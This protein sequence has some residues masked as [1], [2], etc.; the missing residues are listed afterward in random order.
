MRD[1]ETT[2]TVISLLTFASFTISFTIYYFD[3]LRTR[4]AYINETSNLK[5]Y[6]DPRSNTQIRAKNWNPTEIEVH[7]CSN[8]HS[9]FTK[10][11]ARWF[12]KSRKNG[13]RSILTSARRIH[14]LE[15]AR[16]THRTF[17]FPERLLRRNDFEK[18]RVP[19]SGSEREI[20]RL[21][22]KNCKQRADPALSRLHRRKKRKRRRKRGGQ[23]NKE[24]DSI[25]TQACTIDV[26]K[27]NELKHGKEDKESRQE[28]WKRK[29]SLGSV[30]PISLIKKSSIVDTDAERKTSERRIQFTRIV[31]T[32]V[33]NPNLRT[34]SDVPAATGLAR[35][36]RRG[37]GT[38]GDDRKREQG[39]TKPSGKRGRDEQTSR[40]RC[41]IGGTRE[42]N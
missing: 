24:T 34:P 27:I 20:A 41:G 31:A 39:K 13:R 23:G 33:W 3:Y 25:E 36:G 16:V 10:G 11:N 1:T 9:E 2:F 8:A 32:P 18:F 6:N 12:G 4:R 19:R 30:C 21:P 28:I 35:E 22:E 26:T 15:F 40:G 42:A 37:E 5:R 17:P 38:M 29:P 7:S 14:R